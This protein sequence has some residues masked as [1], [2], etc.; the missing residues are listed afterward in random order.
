[1]GCNEFIKY[2]KGDQDEDTAYEE[3]DLLAN[4]NIYVD[5]LV[6][7]YRLQHPVVQTKFL[8]YLQMVCS[9]IFQMEYQLQIIIP[10]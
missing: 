2:V 10:D 5:F 3:L 6:V 4:M 8:N 9:Y 7:D 1:M